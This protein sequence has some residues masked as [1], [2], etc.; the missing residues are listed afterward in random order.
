MFEEQQDKTEQEVFEAKQ[1][2]VGFFELL[3]R[4]DQRNNPKPYED[5]RS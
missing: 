1:N 5:N 4:I 3:L 2:L